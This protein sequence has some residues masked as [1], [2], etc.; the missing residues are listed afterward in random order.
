MKRFYL[1]VCVSIMTKL[2]YCQAAAPTT[3]CASAPSTNDYADIEEVKFGVIN[4]L[5]TCNS[6]TGSQGTGTGTADFY[7]S[8][9]NSSV[10]IPIVTPGSA[11][12]I[13]VIV[14]NCWN[15][16]SLNFNYCGQGKVWLDFNRDGV[17]QDPA[18]M[19]S[20]GGTACFNSSANP[21]TFSATVVAPSTLSEGFTRMRVT[22]RMYENTQAAVTPCGAGGLTNGS[23]WGETED[24]IVLLGPKKWDYSMESLLGP[25]S[26][27]FCGQNPVVI[28][29]GFK[30]T[31]NQPLPGGRVD[32]YIT[33]VEP[34]STTNLFY[35]KTWTQS[36]GVGQSGTVDFNPIQ[37]PKDE[38]VK[39][40]FVTTFTLDSNRSNDTLI[41]FVQVYKNPVYKLKSDTVCADSFNTVQIYDKPLP[42][43][44]KWNNESIVDLTTYTLPSS[45][46]I[47]VQIS[48]GWKCNVVDSIPA[49]V[50]PLPRLTMARDT[51]LCNGQNVD[52]FVQ[53]DLPPR[54]AR[55]DL[56]SNNF[57]NVN[58]SGQYTATARADN[59]CVN[60]GFTTVTIV[61]P[62]T[63]PQVLDT[64]CAGETATVG[65]NNS[66]TGFL[67]KW[68]GRTET[69][70]LINPIPTVA[71]GIEKYYVQWWYQGCT[72]RDTV[73]LKVNPLPNVTMNFPAPICPYFSS[74]IVA[75]GAQQYEWRN[76]L[77]TGTT[78]T[79]SPMTTTD[80][81]V[82]GTDQNGCWKEVMHRQFVYPT[83]EMIVYSNKKN[84]NVCLGDSATIYVNGGKTYSWSTGS[85][86]SI[87]KL[88]PTESF[89]WTMIGTD[90][91]GCKDTLSYRM[92]VKPAF[93]ISYDKTINGC[94]GDVKRLTASGAKEYDWGQGP[95]SDTFNDVTLI[96]STSYQVTATSPHDCQIVVTIPVTVLKKPVGQLS[97]L[98]ICKGET[99]QLE[100]KGGV[101]YDWTINGQ[102]FITPNGH[103]GTYTHN[104]TATIGVEVTNIAGCK[105]TA[106][107]TVNVINTDKLEVVF[108]SPLDSYNCA[109]PKIP[110]TLSATP[111]GGI[112][113]GGSYVT[114]N[115][116]S[117]EGLSGTYQVLYT[118]FEPINNCKVERIKNVK[119]KCTSG[120]SGIDNYADWS[121]YPMPF[122]DKLTVKYTSEKSEDAQLYIYDLSGRE[123]YHYTHRLLPGE[124]LIDL[125]NLQLAK[126]TY[127]LDFQTESVSRQAKM[128]AQ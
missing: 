28:K 62:P 67:Y 112:W 56:N 14:R 61:N 63:Q 33:G 8:F 101:S 70:P 65:L 44:H 34:G 32:L 7:T 41:K 77:G 54:F 20:L 5:T 104:D 120:I 78:K 60:T 69:T 42:L 123:V 57:L 13:D 64:V 118:F 55:W 84:D 4:N 9:V 10:P 75:S 92:N 2:I 30:N 103:L 121:V 40:V 26:I 98:T 73:S 66:I 48:R 24:Y 72:S 108:K 107:T 1:V 81:Y 3:Y 25:D 43:F 16:G 79:V 109:S 91:N 21:T 15:G 68:T 127:Y 18:E 102:T 6:L 97:D 106:Y 38:L 100:A 35:N 114:G 115:K 11:N 116:M 86:D 49:I 46:S 128:I 52:L 113:S 27:S 124:N 111:V 58:A 95:T 126:G 122:S 51:V 85:T 17:F 90:K 96:N 31:G 88:I 19:F 87:L 119:F 76:G 50:K 125:A 22:W 80:Y 99:G 74:T 89:Q 94:E 45:T 23:N 83:P 47:S 105:D 36:I 110:I 59:G 71:S 39:M 93:S 117:P 82:K 29:A 37:F 53:M 12:N